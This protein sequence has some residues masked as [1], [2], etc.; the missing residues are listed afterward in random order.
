MRAQSSLLVLVIPQILISSM[1]KVISRPAIAQWAVTQDTSHGDFLEKI[2]NVGNDVPLEPRVHCIEE[3]CGL[4]LPI[5][6]IEL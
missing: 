3:A 6:R 2:L 4:A 5:N 1:A